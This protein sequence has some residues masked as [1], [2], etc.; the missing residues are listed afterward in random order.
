MCE[1][2]QRG[3]EKSKCKYGYKGVGETRG[4][5]VWKYGKGIIKKNLTSNDAKQ[6]GPTMKEYKSNLVANMTQKRAP[7]YTIYVQKKNVKQYKT[8]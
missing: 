3:V 4:K 8:E 6:F 5:T 7:V 2:I 1:L